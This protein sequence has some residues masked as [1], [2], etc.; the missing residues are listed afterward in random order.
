MHRQSS[1]D[2]ES[3]RQGLMERYGLLSSEIPSFDK[4]SSIQA[5]I[6]LVMQSPEKT[7][8]RE[9][10][11]VSLDNPDYVSNKMKEQV[12][13]VGLVME[14]VLVWNFFGA[15]GIAK[16]NKSVEREWAESLSLLVNKM[17][18]IRVVAG[19][20]FSVWKYFYNLEPSSVP[21]FMA[22]PEPT[23]RNLSN[24]KLRER[25]QVGWDNINK[26]S[27][28][29]DSGRLK[30][31]VADAKAKVKESLG[32]V[33]ADRLKGLAGQVE[34]KVKRSIADLDRDKLSKQIK[35]AKDDMKNVWLD[36]WGFKSG[37]RDDGD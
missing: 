10:G 21:Y 23:K 6:L 16:T 37:K 31:V 34:D 29:E 14:K 1:K 33:D 27:A 18:N 25:F 3:Y 9:T 19:C 28:A 12:N 30:E 15:Y 35:K 17:P 8:C 11:E 24:A 36:A 32:G 22:I 4:R 13:R 5:P 26:Y 7:G 20:G 2:L